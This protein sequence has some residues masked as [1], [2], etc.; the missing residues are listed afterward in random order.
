MFDVCLVYLPKPYLNNPDAQAPLGLMYLA[1]MLELHDYEVTIYNCAALDDDLAIAGL[2]DAKMYGITMTSM[3][4]LQANRFAKRIKDHRPDSVVVAGGPGTLATEYIDFKYFDA[5][6]MGAGEYVI[7]DMLNDMN[8]QC[9]KTFYG[10]RPVCYL[11]A[12]PYPAR[13]LL[14]DSQ[15]GDI[16][17]YNKKYAAGESTII[18]SSRGC[19]CQCAFCTAPALNDKV[20]LREAGE[21]AAEIKHVR[22]NYGIRQFRFSDDMFMID[23]KRVLAMCETIAPLNVYWRVSCRVKPLDSEMLS[24]MHDAGC[25]ELSFGVESFDDDVLTGLKKGTTV[26]DNI[27]AL[28]LSHACDFETRILMMIRTPFQTRKT[29]EYNKYY[30]SRLPYSI[31]ACTAFVPIPGSDVWN[32]PDNYNIEIL[33]RDLDKYNFYMFN[34]NGRRPIDPIIK[35][36]GRSIDEFHRESEEFRDWLEDQKKVNRG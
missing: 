1:S 6:C 19:P 21:V 5:V 13:H 26:A 3:E 36:K 30:L 15:G 17:A 10:N 27:R 14:Q 33:D 24:A 35:I 32:N 28:E 11:D 8:N 2:P 4:V 23:K 7:L 18:L 31:V 9:L 22:D 29:I 25:K 12:L 20:R 34:S 16:F